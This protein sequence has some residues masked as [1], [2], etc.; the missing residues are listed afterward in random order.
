MEDVLLS[1][2][3]LCASGACD[4]LQGACE[5][6]KVHLLVVETRQRRQG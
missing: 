6:Q 5:D 3:D 1:G 4:V 2:S